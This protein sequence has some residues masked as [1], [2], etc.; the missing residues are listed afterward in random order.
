MVANRARP[1]AQVR[2]AP[3]CSA[4]VLVRWAV[5]GEKVGGARFCLKAGGDVARHHPDTIV[6]KSKQRHPHP[7]GPSPVHG[8]TRVTKGTTPAGQG[9]KV[10]LAA[11]YQAKSPV[12]RFVLGFAGVLALFYALTLTSLFK[13]NFFPAYLHFNA[14]AS[15]AA[16]RGLGQ[17][18][19]VS[20]S[21]IASGVW[22]VDVRRGCDA[23]EPTALFV[24]AV[25]AFPAAWRRKWLGV[26]AGIVLLALLN[27]LRIVS[28]FLVGAHF[29]KA[30]D[31]MHETI[32]QA[33][34]ILLA[35]GLW[36]VWIQWAMPPR[37]VPCSEPNPSS[38]S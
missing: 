18:T 22:T 8:A 35:I 23:V 5:Q 38:A 7:L 20:G 28:L 2:N 31:L 9:L 17:R 4:I 29:P 36:A 33:V 10:R 11:W 15:S 13:R 37:R 16:L 12:F 1:R 14:Q 24:A 21:Q 19:T 6:R 27:V 3:I 34:F 30:F 26:G 25:L 32:W